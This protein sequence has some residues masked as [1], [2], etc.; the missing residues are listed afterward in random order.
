MFNFHIYLIDISLLSWTSRYLDVYFFSK[1]VIIRNYLIV[2]NSLWIRI[3]SKSILFLIILPRIT[4]WFLIFNFS[5]N[6][7]KYSFLFIIIYT[8]VVFFLDG[9]MLDNFY[10][11]H[12][13]NNNI[14]L[15]AWFTRWIIHLRVS[16]S[17]FIF[18]LIIDSVDHAESFHYT[19]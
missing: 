4:I 16:Y 9:I 8:N 13:N 2:C 18:F 11:R 12:Y 1:T 7:K 14:A 10:L 17:I 19:P 6:R 15:S 5:S 3:V